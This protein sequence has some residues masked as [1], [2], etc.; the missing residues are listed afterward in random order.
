MS[1]LFSSAICCTIATTS[2]LVT[3]EALPNDVLALLDALV[4]L[5]HTTC[6]WGGLSLYGRLRYQ[7]MQ[8]AKLWP[9]F[10]HYWQMACLLGQPLVIVCLLLPQP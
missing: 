9:T 7:I 2:S 6:G 5:A 1:D 3:V 8:I 10:L 4:V